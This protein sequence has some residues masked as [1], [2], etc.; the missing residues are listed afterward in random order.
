MRYHDDKHNTNNVR[1]YR[2][3]YRRIKRGPGKNRWVKN[4]AVF[5]PTE[6]GISYVFEIPTKKQ[7]VKNKWRK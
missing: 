6:A 1:R 3:W 5:K 7:G 2:F 4:I